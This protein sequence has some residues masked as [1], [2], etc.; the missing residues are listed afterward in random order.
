[1]I[2]GELVTGSRSEGSPGSLATFRIFSGCAELYKIQGVQ[3]FCIHLQKV[4][5]KERKLHNFKKIVKMFTN[6][7]KPW[8]AAHEGLLLGG[9]AL[10]GAVGRE[11]SLD[12]ILTSRVHCQKHRVHMSLPPSMGRRDRGT[13]PCV[14]DLLLPG[15]GSYNEWMPCGSPVRSYHSSAYSSQTLLTKELR[16]HPENMSPSGSLQPVSSR[17]LAK[18]PCIF[19]VPATQGDFPVGDIPRAFMPNTN[20]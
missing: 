2:F 12:E 16:N 20:N 13:T 14:Q 17:T 15:C 10:A 6:V 7:S 18:F 4:S 19:S 8:K 5:K 11:Q 3:I 9:R 1:M